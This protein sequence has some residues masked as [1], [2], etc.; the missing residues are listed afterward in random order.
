[1]QHMAYN[2]F[3]YYENEKQTYMDVYNTNITL[4]NDILTEQLSD[5]NDLID[6]CDILINNAIAAK[7]T[8]IR[9][10]ER[11]MGYF[12]REGSWSSNDY[13][14]PYQQKTWTGVAL[15]D[16]ST[17]GGC[18]IFYDTVPRIGEDKAYLPNG[19]FGNKNFI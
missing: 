6:A 1:M 5:I 17:T 19:A 16:G 8:L 11:T 12:L 14:G 9:N 15:N 2:L 13:K 18:K 3:T 7:Q 4:K 10:F